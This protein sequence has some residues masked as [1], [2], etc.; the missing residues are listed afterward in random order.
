MS[1]FSHVRRRAILFVACS[2]LAVLV[3]APASA[4]GLTVD[5]V[6]RIASVTDAEVSPD[7]AHV[8][9]IRS[10]PRLSLIHISEPTRHTS[11]SRLPG[12]W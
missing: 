2:L 1:Q 9:Y 5:D 11:Q 7:G 8:A 10:V 4:R 12:L 6:A 3:L